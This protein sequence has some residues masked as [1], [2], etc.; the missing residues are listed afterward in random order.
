MADRVVAPLVG[1]DPDLANEF[2][3]LCREI[4]PEPQ[5]A[6][7]ALSV[8]IVLRA[9]FLIAERFRKHGEGM[10]G[11]GPRS[12]H[13][14]HS[15]VSRQSV[16]LGGTLKWNTL[17]EVAATLYFGI[18]TDHA[19]VDA[20][21]RT[22]LLTVL[23]QLLCA[24]RVP[25]GVTQRDLEVLTV[26]TADHKLSEYS[27]YDRFVRKDDPEVRFI[28]FFLKRRT[29]E[30]DNRYY[31]ITY[32]QLD[33]ILNRFGARLDYPSANRIDVVRLT[34]GPRGGAVLSF[35]K[36]RIE[37]RV[38]QIGFHDWGTEVA[39]ADIKHVRDALGLTAANNIDSAVFYE[40]IDPME[41]LIREYNAP[42]LRLAGR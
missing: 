12:L 23:Y 29:R 39:R 7:H 19:F 16:S 28:A 20:N 33:N 31:V 1:V 11:V 3:R 21:K 34:E 5:M 22:A 35:G 10:L 36:K 38:T 2:E 26:R 8:E 18:V 17:F 24:G 14:L 40:G 32:R 15:A 13:L 37:E 27:D 42:L 30:L 4:T 25:D 6:P 41:S 9:H